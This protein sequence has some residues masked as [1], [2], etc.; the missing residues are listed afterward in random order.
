MRSAIWATMLLFSQ[1]PHRFIVDWN[2]SDRSV[3][4]ATVTDLESGF[5][6]IG[7]DV[8]AAHVGVALDHVQTY[9]GATHGGDEGA[10]PRLPPA[11]EAH[12]AKLSKA[13]GEGKATEA[14]LSPFFSKGDVVSGGPP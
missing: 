4:N 6:V 3:D 9:A 13:I 12:F 14:M 11:H 8:A 10:R 7:I 2:P 5:T 1:V